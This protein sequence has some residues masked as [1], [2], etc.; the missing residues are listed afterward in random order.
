MTSGRDT[1][2]VISENVK[3][4]IIIRKGN[5]TT[6]I[7]EIHRPE[8]QISGVAYI[9]ATGIHK[10]ISSSTAQASIRAL[11]VIGDWRR[12]IEIDHIEYVARNDEAHGH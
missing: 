7:A 5:V 12:P 1:P 9:S 8:R 10:R 4:T 6:A 11:Q 3:D 2:F